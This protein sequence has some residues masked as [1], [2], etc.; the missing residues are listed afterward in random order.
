MGRIAIFP[1]NGLPLTGRRNIEHKV[2]SVQGILES[3]E[4]RG[5]DEIG[6]HGREVLSLVAKFLEDADSSADA[7]VALTYYY[8]G[9]LHLEILSHQI[10]T[11]HVSIGTREQARHPMAKLLLRGF[12]ERAGLSSLPVLVLGDSYYSTGSFAYQGPTGKRIDPFYQVSADLTDSVLFLPALSHE[13]FHCRLSESGFPVLREVLVERGLREDE[14]AQRLEEALCDAL[15]TRIAG[16]AFVYAF[17]AKYWQ[18]PADEEGNHPRDSFRHSVMYAQLRTLFEEP[19]LHRLTGY[20]QVDDRDAQREPLWVVSLEIAK[21]ASDLIPEG[22]S[23][24][25]LNDEDLES[26]EH[27]DPIRLIN[28]AWVG[29]L[30]KRWSFDEA[31]SSVSKVLERWS[32]SVDPT[33]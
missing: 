24:E 12:S 13:V 15:A 1:V 28:A 3:L 32:R 26:A 33:A 27:H 14:D 9:W 11:Y 25:F 20:W 7:E 8:L 5:F 31:D 23:I 4:S 22:P 19:I 21:F 18:N 6:R 10:Q 17:V 16:P 29:V 30:E 2:R